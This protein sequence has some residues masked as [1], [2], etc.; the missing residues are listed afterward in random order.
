MSL[1][2]R[3]FTRVLDSSDNNGRCTLGAQLVHTT[4]KKCFREFSGSI[5]STPTEFTDFT[6]FCTKGSVTQESRRSQE[7]EVRRVPPSPLGNPARTPVFQGFFAFRRSVRQACH[8]VQPRPISP[9]FEHLHKLDVPQRRAGIC[10]R[11]RRQFPHFERA[12]ILSGNDYCPRSAGVHTRTSLADSNVRRRDV[13]DASAWGGRH[14][15]PVLSRFGALCGR[16]PVSELVGAGKTRWQSAAKYVEHGD[17]VEKPL[18][19]FE[20][21]HQSQRL[22]AE[23]AR[24]LIFGGSY[25]CS[26][27]VRILVNSDTEMWSIPPHPPACRTARNAGRRYR[28]A[29]IIHA[30]AGWF[31]LAGLRGVSSVNGGEN[32]RVRPETLAEP[33][34]ALLTPALYFA[35]PCVI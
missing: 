26:P 29:P 16:A 32:K 22:V 4:G 27:S 17:G 2:K 1:L 15:T 34:A 33:F 31:R 13:A 6:R 24:I 28:I 11:R 9:E 35:P 30:V 25:A 18:I 3:G 12:G 19:S 8:N 23:F 21:Q 7:P 5:G 20:H 14:C 10:V